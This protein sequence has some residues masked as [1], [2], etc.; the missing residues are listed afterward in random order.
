MFQISVWS[1]CFNKGNH[2]LMSEGK[3]NELIFQQIF[4]E[5]DLNAKESSE[6]SY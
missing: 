2:K 5:L 6:K 3:I 4:F 1:L